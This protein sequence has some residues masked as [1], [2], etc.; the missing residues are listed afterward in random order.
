MA[1]F[2]PYIVAFATG[3]VVSSIA[4]ALS[5]NNANSDFFPPLGPWKLLSIALNTCTNMAS[6]ISSLLKA[7]LITATVIFTALAATTLYFEVQ[8]RL[9]RGAM[10]VRSKL[11]KKRNRRYTADD[12]DDHGEY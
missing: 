4:L 5:H 11:K 10:K 8:N 6:S 3:I 12:Y 2:A 1:L 9:K 7:S